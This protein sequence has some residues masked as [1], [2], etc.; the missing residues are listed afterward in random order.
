MTTRSVR[1]ESDGGVVRITLDRPP[2]NVLDRAM[3]EELTT[4]L[5]VAAAPGVKVVLLTG[6][7][8]AFCAGV[9]V[10]DH[11]ADRVDGMIA[12][13]HDAIAALLSLEAPVVG[14]VNGAALGGGCELVLACDMVIARE[15]AKLGQPEI[16]LGVFPP[17]AAVL[18]PR[19]AGRQ[20]AL[21]LILT[22]RTI[23]AAEAVPLGLVLRA[24]PGDE[25]D[26]VVE[27]YL[28][29][30]ADLSAPVLRV[31]KRAVRR[32]L[33][34]PVHSALREADR[35]YLGDL[36]QLHDPYEGLAAFMEKREP[37]WS[38]A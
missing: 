25:F 13:F 19:I 33:E 1:V 30:L 16:R 14:A 15:H 7:G 2:L 38:D 3:L 9:D 32:G 34:Q 20:Q 6:A 35:I 12:A 37:I 18:L 27:S 31:A 17:A 11:T 29:Q 8:R 5:A 26:A 10:A 28:A 36:M 22:G 23:S 4:A 24:V 21:D